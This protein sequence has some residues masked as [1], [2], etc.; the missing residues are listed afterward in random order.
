MGIEGAAVLDMV[1]GTGGV[2]G[3]V[4]EYNTALGAERKNAS[5]TN[6]GFDFL[7]VVGALGVAD[8]AISLRIRGVRLFIPMGGG[9]TESNEEA[10]VDTGPAVEGLL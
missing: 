10:R 8:G 1:I 5:D 4:C 2:P 9:A 7:C 3:V 6:D